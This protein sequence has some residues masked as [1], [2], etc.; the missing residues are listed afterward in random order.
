M[1]KTILDITKK[2]GEVQEN[3]VSASGVSTVK[4]AVQDS[5]WQQHDMDEP[6]HLLSV[7]ISA[8]DRTESVTSA[9]ITLGGLTEGDGCFDSL[10]ALGMSL[11]QLAAKAKENL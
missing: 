5:I 2:L 6:L 3:F 8:S 1:S 7:E 11:I 9:T 4:V 10:E